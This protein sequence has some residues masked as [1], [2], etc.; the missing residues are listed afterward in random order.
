MFLGEYKRLMSERLGLKGVKEDDF[1][2]LF[3]LLFDVMEVLELDF[4][5]FFRRL[6]SVKVVDLESEEG[7]ME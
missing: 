1:D 3:S 4:N 2:G 7:R 5:L 6:L